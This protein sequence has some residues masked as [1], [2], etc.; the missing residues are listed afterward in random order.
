MAG[1]TNAIKYSYSSISAQ[2]LTIFR[3][4][5]YF[6]LGTSEWAGLSHDDGLADKL[7]YRNSVGPESV[8]TRFNAGKSV[9]VR[10]STN[11]PTNPTPYPTLIKKELD[12]L[13]ITAPL[14]IYPEGVVELDDLGLSGDIDLKFDGTNSTDANV[15]VDDAGGWY[16]VR[17]NFN[18]TYFADQD[19]NSHDNF[20]FALNVGTPKTN[21]QRV[22]GDFFTR[23]VRKL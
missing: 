15:I 19:G 8:L 11:I 7:F 9:F 3:S 22:M 10:N 14:N 17:Q 4:N 21:D 6:S 2:T 20:K 13:H 1:I 16:L 23:K 5:S 12:H 18:G